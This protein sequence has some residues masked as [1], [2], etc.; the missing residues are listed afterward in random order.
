VVVNLGHGR[1]QAMVRAPWPEL[2]G[3]TLRLEDVLD[4]TVY[5][6]RGGDLA[7]PGVYVE[8]GPGAWHLLAVR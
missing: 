8:L 7:G 3:R 1:A 4:G 2:A 6:R 5:G